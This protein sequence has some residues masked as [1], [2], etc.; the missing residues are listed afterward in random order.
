MLVGRQ[1]QISRIDACLAQAR[2]GRSAGLLLV[3]EAGIG[4]TALLDEGALRAAESGMHVIRATALEVESG[5]PAGALGLVLTGLGADPGGTP[6]SALLEALIAASEKGPLLLTVDDVQWFDPQSLLS[7]TFATRRLLAD[8]VAVLAAARPSAGVMTT[9]T[10]LPRVD[11][12]PLTPIACRELLRGRYPAMPSTTADEIATSLGRVPLPLVEVGNLL[13]DEVLAGRA[14]VPS[15]IPVSEAVQERYARGFADLG[16]TEQQALVLL[17]ADDT[18]DA[19]VLYAARGE[20]DLPLGVWDR[21][22]EAGLVHQGPVL[23]FVHPLARAAIHAAAAPAV[24]RAAH[25]ALGA[26]LG[27]QGRELNSA[28]HLAQAAT[29]PD[30]E[31]AALLGKLADVAATVPGRR[32]EAAA[33]AQEAARLAVDPR[34]HDR[35]LV[36][37]AECSTGESA[38][39][40]A[41]DVLAR[42]HDPD[43]QARCV[44]VCVD[45]ESTDPTALV[46][47]TESIDALPLSPEASDQHAVAS[48][49][50]AVMAGDVRRLESLA[51]AQ[52]QAG[53]RV[54]SWE[55]QFALGCALTFAGRHREGVRWLRRAMATSAEVDP[56]R[57]SPGQLINWAQVP[58][59]LGTD[60]PAHRDRF[61]RMERLLRATRDP[62]DTVTAAFFAAEHARRSGAWTRAVALGREAVDISRDTGADDAINYA[63]LASL[64]A[65]RGDE[66]EATSLLQTAHERFQTVPSAWYEAALHE[67]EGALE[68]AAGRQANAIARLVPL[69]DM[70]FVGRGA[71]EIKTIGLLDLA[72]AYALTGDLA[73]AAEVATYLARALDGV[74]D[75]FGPAVVSRCR[76]L[77]EPADADELFTD[78]LAHLSRTVEVFQ[79]ARTELLQGEHLRR[80]R[81]PRESREPLRRALTTFE[82][83][84]ARPW[85]ARAARELAAAG[86]RAGSSRAGTG[87]VG[88]SGTQSVPA[89]LTPQELRIALAVTEGMTNAQV[90][91]TLFLSVK[92]VEFHLG[93][94]YRKLSVTSRGGLARALTDHG[95]LPR[96][97]G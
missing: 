27:A 67:A 61:R 21:C 59:W 83:L 33:L 53:G 64:L 97:R 39:V 47:L 93:N 79:T 4:K 86:G 48:M 76:A 34:E 5:I 13:D 25:A 88:P 92:T 32:A 12:P 50:A 16:P 6:V 68:V 2:D 82:H 73:S 71:H 84:G 60:W 14:P 24:R 95:E 66:A 69:L 55:A 81:R 51:A 37:A 18:A 94:A 23:A 11:V 85:V 65:H 20:L 54:K 40:L 43:L 96:E 15:P 70:P 80:T 62:V 72:E 7:L 58:G 38:A 8:P 9:L 57:L 74:A 52:D 77:A 17:A 10:A 26:V 87:A 19:T 44:H 36:V 63:R 90:A 56:E 41:R 91:A 75:P 29:G 89:P 42:T 49:W 31:L 22:E 46:R 35:M 3:G 45:H 1:E 30:A 28:H 78:A